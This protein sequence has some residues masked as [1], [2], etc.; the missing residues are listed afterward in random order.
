MI[1]IS[2]PMAFAEFLLPC[3]TNCQCCCAFYCAVEWKLVFSL[4]ISRLEVE[5]VV[6]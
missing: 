3:I 4:Y 6:M 1:Y 2:E 5:W